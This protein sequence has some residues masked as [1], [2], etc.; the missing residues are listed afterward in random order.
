MSA[1]PAVTKA[2][3]K[4]LTFYELY[5]ITDEKLPIDV[6]AVRKKYRKM[7]VLFHPD[8]DPSA[9][10]IFEHIKLALDTLTDESRRKDYDDA[11][12][13]LLKKTKWETEVHQNVHQAGL[14]VS[15][16]EAE[17]IARR[18][19]QAAA[20]RVRAHVV[21]SIHSELMSAVRRCPVR[22]AEEEM[23]DDWD[24]DVDLLAAKETQVQMLLD[25]LQQQSK[26]WRSGEHIQ[27]AQ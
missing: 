21:D 20:E 15:R 26:R 23:L 7:S 9:R 2:N 14:D 16:R 25:A 1:P 17:A 6:T 12:L 19:Q 8:K 18:Q 11:R 24:V 4:D 13:D 3:F 5:G 10:D 27:R 22:A